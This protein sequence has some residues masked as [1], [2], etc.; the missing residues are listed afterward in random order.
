MPRIILASSSNSRKKL[1]ESAGLTFD[2]IV[3]NV[4]EEVPIYQSMTPKEM[5]IALS[6]VKAHTVRELV[7]YP[8]LLLACDSTFE[9]EGKS[10]GKPFTTEVAIARARSLS[11]KS[12]Y[13]HTGHCIIDLENGIEISDI[14]TTKVNFGEMNDQE[15]ADYVASGE[16]LLV[17]GGFTLDGLSSAFIDSIEGDYTNVIGLSVPLLRS[18][19]LRLGYSWHDLITQP[20]GAK[21]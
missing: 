14:A 19:I 3:S 11:G 6:I 12:G 17:A 15:I 5:V 21:N 4:D 1:L 13:L 9:F 2:V 10:L 18:M 20:I 16:P 7:D 8:A